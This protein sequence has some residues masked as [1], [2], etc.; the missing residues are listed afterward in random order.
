MRAHGA[1]TA[2]LVVLLLHAEVPGFS[3]GFLGVSLFF[4]LSGFLI[5]QLLLGE[6]ARTGR[7]GLGGFWSRRIRRLAPASAG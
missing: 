4:T 1:R 6:R 5:T 3:G 2:Q 7:I